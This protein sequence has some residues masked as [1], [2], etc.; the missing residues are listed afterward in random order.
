VR[1]FSGTITDFPK[2]LARVRPTML[3]TVPRLLNMFYAMLSPFSHVDKKLAEEAWAVK[4]AN[5]EKGIMTSQY[6][7]TVFKRAKDVFGGRVKR[8][9]TG[10][11]PIAAEVLR[12]FRIV[13]GCDIREG[14][15]QTETTAG[16]FFTSSGEKRAG[17]VGGVNRAVEFKLV[18]IPEMNYSTDTDPP[19]GEICVRGDPIFKGYYKDEKNT[20]EAIDKDGWHHTGDV[21]L[22]EKN[23]ALRLIDRKKNIYKLSQGEYVAPEKIENIYLRCPL[24]AEVFVY[25]D[26]LQNYNVGIIV[27]NKDVLTKIASEKGI[28]KSF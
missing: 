19:K 21:G 25:G 4:Q 14:Y 3:I 26:S 7:E 18:D 16:T 9:I 27:P 10:S 24:A 6:D 1:F 22:I 8:M 2:D 11:A 15:G 28:N 17:H 13:L 20:K 5:W 23:G 12:F